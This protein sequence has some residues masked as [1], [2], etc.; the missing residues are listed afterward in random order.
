VQARTERE[1]PPSLA[2]PVLLALAALDAAGYSLIAPVL[3]EISRA[4]GTGPASI[5]VLVATFPLGIMLGFPVAGRLIQRGGTERVLVGS[6]LLVA[7]GSAGF[8]VWSGMPAYMGSRFL[9]GIGSGGLWMGVT[10]ST[11]ERWPDQAYL[12]M[13]RIFAA[14]SVGGLVG[15]ALGA[16]GG[17]R[18]PF[19]AYLFLTLTCA[20]PTLLLSPPEQRHSFGSDRDAL[21][22]PGFVL[23]SASILF[24]VLALGLLEGVLPLHFGERLA[25]AQVA[26]LYVGVSVVVAAAAAIA[27]RFRPRSVVGVAIVAIVA[28]IAVS[29]A[30]DAPLVWILSLAVAGVGVGAGN[31]GSIG[32]L[33]DAVPAGRI[34]TAM[35]VWSQL[36]IL[37][38]LIGPLSGGAIAEAFGFA[39]LGVVPLAAA[40]GVLAASV[41]T[42]RGARH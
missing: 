40:T 37:G 34:M 2:Y 6:L 22:R 33:L 19:L 23:A 16:I 29:A 21:R 13:S 3:P 11:L 8:L 28:G 17:I 5:G 10:L 27:G 30:A 41:W 4:T 15:P 32:I 20:V 14:Y 39:A 1:Q 42:G 35:I 36:G 26:A 12:C 24:V 31:T 18:G 9:M 7:A 38:Y 25:Q